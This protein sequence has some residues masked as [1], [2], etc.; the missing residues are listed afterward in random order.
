[1][2]ADLALD[3][4]ERVDTLLARQ[5]AI[6]LASYLAVAYHEPG[7]L[8]R[9]ERDLHLMMVRPRQPVLTQAEVDEIYR[10]AEKAQ[11]IA[12]RNRRRRK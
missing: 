5:K 10:Q 8:S 1:M 12:R 9:A 3:E 6:E 2:A 11:R 7:G 4:L